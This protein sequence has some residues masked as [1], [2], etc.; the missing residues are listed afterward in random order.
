MPALAIVIGCL[1]AQLPRIT[2]LASRISV[3]GSWVTE[4]ARTMRPFNRK[5]N[6]P[7]TFSA[8]V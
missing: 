1:F 3:L 8:Q 5:A 2:E 7:A 4:T 6:S